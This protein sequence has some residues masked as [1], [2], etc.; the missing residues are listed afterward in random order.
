MAISI[1][2]YNFEGPYDSSDQLARRSGVYVVGNWKGKR[3]R[4]IDVGESS[5]IRNR[6]KTHDRK[7]CWWQQAGNNYQFCVHYAPEARRMS[8]AKKIREER[9]LPCGKK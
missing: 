3:P 9:N 4:I 8:I 5:D 6:I 7:N 2:G 1:S